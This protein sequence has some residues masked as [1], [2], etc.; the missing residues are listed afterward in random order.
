[1]IIKVVKDGKQNI[2]F[3]T[4]LNFKDLTEIMGYLFARSEITEWSVEYF[5]TH[6]MNSEYDLDF[7]QKEIE[8]L[9]SKVL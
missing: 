9:K 6:E 2:G 3:N 1:M 8:N 5:E 7:K 4:N